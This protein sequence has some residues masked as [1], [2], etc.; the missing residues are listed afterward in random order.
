MK[1]LSLYILFLIFLSCAREKN[2]GI[3][4][5]DNTYYDQAYAYRNENR[6]DSAFF[7]F[8]LAKDVF[9]ESKDSL[10]VANCLLQMA[11]I[12]TDQGDYYGG[13]ETSLQAG[14]YLE[15]SNL[16]HHVYLA[17]NFNNLGIA[18]HKLKD[19]QNSLKFYES[20]IRFATDSLNIRVYLNNKAKTLQ[21]EGSFADA[22]KIYERI[23]HESRKN[24][25]GYARALTNYAMTKW[26]KDPGYDPQPDLL[27]ALHIRLHERDL[28]GQNSSYAHLAD[29]YVKKQPDSALSYARKR[30]ITA[31]QLKSGDDL[32]QALQTLIRLGSTDSTKH[33]FEEYRQLNDSVQLARRAAKNQFALI[34]YEVEKNKADN[35]RLQKENAEKAYQLSRQRISTAIVAL[36]ALIFSAGGSYW[37]KKRKQRLEL[38]AQN[39]IRAH[40]LKTSKK[41]HD[42][43]AN[44]LYRVMAEIENQNHVDREGILDKLENMYEK[45]RDISYETEGLPATSHGFH[46]KITNLLASFATDSTKVVIAGND[47]GVWENLP[48]DARH[49]IEHILQELMVNMRKHSRASNVAVR[50]EQQDSALHIYYTDNGI[51]LPEAFQRR[52]GLTNTGNRIESLRGVITFGTEVGK[53]LKIHISF[54][55]I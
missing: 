15:Q 6:A 46:E 33:Y 43:V 3:R 51:G 42:V 8:N 9:L 11:I 54:P 13:Q 10:S 12:L 48:L 17:A 53:G 25:R 22:L 20:A 36:L 47:P 16:E 35:L 2:Q 39:R 31:R 1:N 50:F 5:A 34:R 27:R 21:Q 18:A 49:E 38:E 14:E 29:Y 44:G 28:W 7:Y 30:Y 23:L 26:Y 32:I 19:Y 41:I 45:S 24:P 37:Y 4:S 40:Q 55:V 52:N